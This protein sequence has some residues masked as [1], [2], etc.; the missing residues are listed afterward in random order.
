MNVLAII[1]KD[2]YTFDD[3]TDRNKALVRELRLLEDEFQTF[4]YYTAE[5][6]ETILGKMKREVAAGVIAQ[7]D[8]WLAA[9]IADV[10]ISLIENQPEL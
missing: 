4:D 5:P 10:Q 7:V 6:E 8:D 9:Y 3:L 1:E 2:G